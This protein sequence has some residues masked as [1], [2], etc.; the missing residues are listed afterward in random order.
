MDGETILRDAI[1]HVANEVSRQSFRGT[2]DKLPQDYYDFKAANRTLHVAFY[3]VLAS[4]THHTA[5]VEGRPL[6]RP[7]TTSECCKRG[8]ALFEDTDL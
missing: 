2:L 7:M 8:I 4:R 6:S 5:D 1:G 3:D